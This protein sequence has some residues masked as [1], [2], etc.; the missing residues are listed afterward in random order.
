MADDE[1]NFD[2]E[3]YEGV[4]ER[5]INLPRR[6]IRRFEKDRRERD[7]LK[8]QLVETE[9]LLA[10]AQAGI[11]PTEP[12]AKYFVKGYDGDMDPE[13]IRAAAVEARVIMS[14]VPVSAAE[15]GGHAALSA[16]ANGGQPTSMEDDVTR[17][18]SETAKTHWREA[19]KAV[20]EIMR[21]VEAND[22][23]LHVNT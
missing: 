9:R 1:E 19:D 14:G 4:Q 11:N 3:D 17:Q 20:S 22:I 15:Q 18:L 23:K 7:Q 21:I 2:P 13:A 12:A 8:T 10:F 16:A 5:N 6:E